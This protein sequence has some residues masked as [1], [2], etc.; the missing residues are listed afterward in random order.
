MSETFPSMDLTI[1]GV[2]GSKDYSSNA[3]VHVK[4][5]L[6]TLHSTSQY[7]YLVSAHRRHP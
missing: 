3:E 4:L 5:C 7:F 1:R 6:A 2:L